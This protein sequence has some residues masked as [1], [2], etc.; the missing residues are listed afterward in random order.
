MKNFLLSLLSL[1]L[2]FSLCAQSTI[3]SITAEANKF[4][5]DIDGIDKL[6]LF[7]NSLRSGD[8][9]IYLAV[10]KIAA[11]KA[12]V[13]KNDTL[14]CKAFINIGIACIEMSN[15]EEAS[16]YL[17]K[18]KLLA[19][20]HNNNFLLMR[21]T[22]NTG[23]I[24]Y[25][26]KQYP[27]ALEYYLKSLELAKKTGNKKSQIVSL[28]NIGGVYYDLGQQDTKQLGAALYY[29]QQAF[30]LAKELNDTFQ[31]VNQSCNLALQLSDLHKTDSAKHYLSYARTMIEE[32]DYYNLTVYYSNMG[33]VSREEKKYTEAIAYYQKTIDFGEKKNSPEWVFESYLAIS[34][35][36]EEKGN[37]NKAFEFYKKYTVLR[38]SSINKENFDKAADIQNKYE[39]AKKDKELLQKD[40][41]LKINSVKR[42][43]LVTF[44]VFSLIILTLLGYFSISLLKNIKARKKAYAELEK[45]NEEIK[46]QALQL[47]QQARL[48]AKFQSQMNPHFTFNALHNIYGLVIGNENEKAVTQ[49]Q[50]LAQ[51]MRKTLTNSI[52]EEITLE[53]E[54]DYLQ[55]YIAFEQ[56]TASAKFN[57]GIEIDKDLENALIPP[58]MI[59]PFIENAIKHG[60]LDKVNN[61]FIKV[62]IQKEKDLMSLI[63]QDNGKGLD[64]NNTNISK[65]SH[66]MS[67]IK[68]RLELLFQD[69]KNAAADGLLTIKNLSETNSGTSIQFY[70]PLN[71]SY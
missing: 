71:Y 33:R 50:S 37:T 64:M 59:Q 40:I 30:S 28:G 46:E 57:F 2:P 13:I 14:L 67:I 60:E 68:S 38:D 29:A 17:A 7:A 65:L 20:K 5:N 63:I 58:M 9:D 8:L 54:V 66:S 48:I 62:L 44:L 39:R 36:Y 34:E 55:N 11:E 24:Y 22:G 35:I 1:F 31:L 69:K 3:D 16:A 19:E 6:L 52:K 21:I 53:E 56:A 23:R 51:L 47:S 15:S 70:L 32:D 43:R 49:I 45:R 61:P 12:E 25:I 4:S 18:A 42:N 26:N 41:A 27:K 10:N